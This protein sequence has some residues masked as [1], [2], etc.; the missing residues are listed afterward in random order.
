MSGRFKRAIVLGNLILAMAGLAH[1]QSPQRPPVGGG[2]GSPGE[3]ESA[4]GTSAPPTPMI[5]YV[6]HG[7]TGA[8]GPTCSEW[9]AAEGSV[10]WDTYKRLIAILD[11]QGRRKL[12]LV[13]NAWGFADVNVAASLGRILRDRGIDTTAGPTEAA[14]CNGKSR[15]ECLDLK[16]KGESLEAKIVTSRAT[17]DLACIF[18]LAG[19]VHRNLP[20]ETKVAVNG[21]LRIYNRFAPNVSEE[22]RK[23]LGTIFSEKHHKYLSDM[24]VDPQLLDLGGNSGQWIRIPSSQW[25]RFRIITDI[26]L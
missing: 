25:L 7:P 18:I 16:R 5:F 13:I 22:Q 15:E 12:P 24:G 11:R 1:A 8:C 21:S 26:S 2:P 4:D 17:C 23:S 19:G 14:A 9:I 6:A 3:A 10:Q 20:P